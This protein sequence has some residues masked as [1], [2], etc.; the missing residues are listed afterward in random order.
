METFNIVLSIVA[1][2]ASIFAAVQTCKSK[3]EIKRL[4]NLYEGNIQKAYGNGNSQVMGTGNRV[5]GRGD[6]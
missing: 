2:V 4:R 3:R 5:V 6:R 1:S